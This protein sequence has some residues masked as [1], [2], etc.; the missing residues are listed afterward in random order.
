MLQIH[1][2]GTVKRH[3]WDLILFLKIYILK[4]RT[5]LNY[6]T[7]RLREDVI[8]FAAEI[9]RATIYTRGPWVMCCLY[10]GP[11]SSFDE[12]N[13]RYVILSLK[14]IVVPDLLISK[15]MRGVFVHYRHWHDSKI[16]QLKYRPWKSH[17][18]SAAFRTVPFCLIF[19]V[20]YPWKY[21]SL[22]L[23]NSWGH[24]L[25]CFC[26]TELPSF[27]TRFTII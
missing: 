6:S 1:T 19:R 9:S 15:Q 23:L 10:E 3:C 22:H 7:N 20:F 25:T 16:S 27:R 24:G 26:Q 12:K 14:Q 21:S 4:K 11:C 18:F 17:N 8:Q 5:D 2:E 13:P